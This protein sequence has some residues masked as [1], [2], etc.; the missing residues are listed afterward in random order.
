VGVYDIHPKI[1]KFDKGFFLFIRSLEIV[2]TVAGKSIIN[3]RQ[4]NFSSDKINS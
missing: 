2:P 3:R 1:F 4:F